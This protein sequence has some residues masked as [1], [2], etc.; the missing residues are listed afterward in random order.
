M[1]YM[2]TKIPT[3]LAINTRGE[4]MSG[5]KVVDPRKMTDREFMKEW[6]R[7]EA[8][9]NDGDG[10]GGDGSVGSAFFGGLF[11]NTK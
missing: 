3:L 11:G 6:I 8:G 5:T 4:I 2:I 1:R 10:S 7:T 9:R